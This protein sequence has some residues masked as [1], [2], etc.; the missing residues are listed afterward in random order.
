MLRESPLGTASVCR[1]PLR[2]LEAERLSAVEACSCCA[3]D[4]PLRRHLSRFYRELEHSFADQALTGNA[5][6][7]NQPAEDDD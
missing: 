3:M 7:P 5:Q 1:C 4:E 6:G 2:A